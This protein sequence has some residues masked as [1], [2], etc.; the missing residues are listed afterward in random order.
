VSAPSAANGDRSGT[1]APCREKEVKAAR[2]KVKEK[3]QDEVVA[4]EML[5]TRWLPRVDDEAANFTQD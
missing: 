3:I 2:F 5:A 4:R 1:F